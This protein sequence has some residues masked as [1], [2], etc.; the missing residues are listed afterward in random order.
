MLKIFLVVFLPQLCMGQKKDIFCAISF[1]VAG[2]LHGGREAFHADP[3]VFEKLGAKTFGF[4]G[5][6]QWQRNY[7]GQR[8][9][10][11]YGAVNPHKS[12]ILGNFGRDFWHTAHYGGGILFFSGTFVIA[13]DKKRSIRRRVLAGACG[14][15]VF[16][17]SSYITY[18]ILR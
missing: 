5:S 7:V 8:Y 2:S 10:N 9:I 3:Y 4:F 13:S 12:E 6:N 15:L 1:V 14:L 11:A 17:T 18:K 16:H